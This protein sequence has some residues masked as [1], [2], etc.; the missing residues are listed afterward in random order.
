MDRRTPDFVDRIPLTVKQ[1]LDN[2]LINVDQENFLLDFILR[3]FKDSEAEITLGPFRED[4]VEKG[5]TQAERL[6]Y[7][8]S[9]ILPD[10]VPM[11]WA[12]K[13]SWD[14]I[15][16]RDLKLINNPGLFYPEDPASV[17]RAPRHVRV[18]PGRKQGGACAR[19]YGRS[20]PLRAFESDV[21]LGRVDVN[22][23]AAL[24]RIVPERGRTYQFDELFPPGV[25]PGEVVGACC[26]Y[27]R[28]KSL[29]T[30]EAFIIKPSGRRAS[31]PSKATTTRPPTP[32]LKD[33]NMKSFITII[34]RPQRAPRPPAPP[35]LVK[36]YTAS[37]LTTYFVCVG[38]QSPI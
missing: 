30:L 26:G 5:L 9:K 10:Y 7:K 23:V 2:D 32:K 29:K 22:E 14:N 12:V 11:P 36:T 21:Q 24:S 37:K 20:W 28:D 3:I 16:R 19:Q 35:V 38:R 1:A 13:Y 15:Y 34:A 8:L 27:H 17:P 33:A 4:V 18:E 25:F 6:A 31:R